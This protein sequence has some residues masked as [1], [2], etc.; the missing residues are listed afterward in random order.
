MTL[1]LALLVLLSAFL[2]PLW[3]TLVKRDQQPETAFLGLC[4]ALI[5]IALV[6][7]LVA[8]YDIMAAVDVWPLILWSWA[9]QMLYG[10]ALVITLR[11]GDLS[12]YYPIIRSSPLPIVVIGVVFLGESYDILTL[13][14]IAAVLAGAFLLQYRPGVKF[15]DPV[16]LMFAVIAMAGTAIYSIAD[17]RIMQVIPPPVMMIWVQVLFFPAYVLVLSRVEVPRPSLRY[18]FSWARRPFR[19]LAIGLVCYG[20]YYLI[21]F[22][23]QMGG[24]VAA[25][26]SVRQAS[27]PFSVLIGGLWLK[28]QGMGRRLWASVLLAAG[29]VV[30][31]VA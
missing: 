3:V 2:H 16:T 28:E 20:S 25:V 11:R 10:T 7:A 1:F 18:L 21:L 14:G 4:F 8:G 6:H 19:Y 15:D 27:I 13:A 26:T 24:D 29:I 17:S 31:V 5:V 30:I 12:A 9:G 23:Y 22:A